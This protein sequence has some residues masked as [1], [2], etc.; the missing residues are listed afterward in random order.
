MILKPVGSLTD[1]P[2]NFDI[3]LSADVGM[4]ANDPLGFVK[5]IFPWG[6]DILKGEAGPDEWQTE[7]LSYLGNEIRKGVATQ[8]AMKAT[9]RMA[10]A[11]GHG[12]GKTAL[13]AWI[14]LWFLSTRDAPQIV[15]T[16][17][18]QT[19]LSTKT[20]RELAK[21]HQKALNRHWFV[22]T[23]T[24]LYHVLFPE[25]W[26]ASAIPWSETNPTAFAGTHEKDVLLIFDEASEIADIIWE[27]AEGGTTTSGVIWL[28][29]GN[30]T[31][32]SGRFYDCFNTF[33]HRWK[34]YEVDSRKA[35]AANKIQIQQW[36]DDYGDDSD[37]VRIRILGKFP[38]LS[39]TQFIGAD[40]V[41]E[42]SQRRIHTSHYN[43]QR[44]IIGVDVA[45][46][47]SDDSIILVRQ[48][49]YV[50]PPIK[51]HGLDTMS[52]AAKVVD[53]YRKFGTQSVICIDGVGLGAGVVDRLNQ[54]GLSVIDVQSAE[55]STDIKTY[56]N[57][58]SELW[59]KMR[60]WIT[61]Y[62]QIPKDNDFITQLS[63]LEYGL[64]KKL[65][66]ILQSKEDL[67]KQGK[68]SPDLADALAY[69]FAYDEMQSMSIQTRARAIKRYNW[70]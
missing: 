53:V 16:A 41:M 60:D 70:A 37:F 55:K 18:T 57:K 51:D 20:W 10:V 50:H 38:R 68:K 27:T 35:K 39:S 4:F 1:T 69:T 15:V 30:P 63:S 17:N 44:P 58:R 14:I 48:G 21:W 24:K 6:S 42:A 65:Q 3:Q 8:E 25:L 22:W 28:A 59:G 2:D 34:T 47:G 52:L 11:S 43:Q 64:N 56:A 31:K 33:K 9:I 26:Y 45:R 19:Q 66:I 23:A 29:F 61:H 36:I 40:V 12:V 7:F 46:F 49:N 13:V 62:G 5:Y 54:L 67:R 32:N